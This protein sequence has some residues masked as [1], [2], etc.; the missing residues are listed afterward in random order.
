MKRPSYNLFLPSLYLIVSDKSIVMAIMIV[1][2][3]DVSGDH[4]E[5][6][7]FLTCLC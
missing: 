5:D 2:K 4:V 6:K 1:K 7:S 3:N